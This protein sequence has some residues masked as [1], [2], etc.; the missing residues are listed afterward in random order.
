MGASE[1]PGMR[2][3]ISDDG[4]SGRFGMAEMNERARSFD[5]T[6]ARLV[7]I[8]VLVVAVGI[9]NAG[10]SSADPVDGVEAATTA[11]ADVE[12]SADTSDQ[13]DADADPAEVAADAADAAD[14]TVNDEDDDEAANDQ[15][16]GDDPSAVA[17]ASEAA[18]EADDVPAA[19]GVDRSISYTHIDGL[20]LAFKNA[21]IDL[22]KAAETFAEAG[23]DGDIPDR[24]D[25]LL[26]SIDHPLTFDDVAP[27]VRAALPEGLGDSIDIFTLL[28][29]QWGLIG[30]EAHLAGQD[31]QDWNDNLFGFL[32]AQAEDLPVDQRNNQAGMMVNGANAATAHIC[33][34]L[35]SHL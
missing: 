34:R 33:P 12:A 22:T 9:A 17:D 3:S 24:F 25:A 20:D 14:D 13:D 4:S 7:G 32:L 6:A 28:S 5:S 2:C 18:T 16:T 30:C 19:D 23:G 31:A 35:Q 27:R 21:T 10:C 8:V 26:A 15:D 11:M 1:Y 29:S